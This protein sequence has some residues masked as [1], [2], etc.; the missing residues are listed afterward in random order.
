[1]ANGDDGDV[2][3]YYDENTRAFLAR[4][5]G[6]SEG[7]LHRG[8]WGEGV[9][10]R[11]GAFHFVHE[12]L[13]REIETL[14]APCPRILDLGC[15]VGASLLYLLERQAVEGFGITV[16]GEQ[17]ERVR[18]HGGA[19]WLKGD[20]CKDP[21]PAELDL[22]YG[23]ESFLHASDAVAFFRNVSQA[24]RR[25][26]RLVLVDDFLTTGAPDEALV[27]DFAWGWHAGSLL[28]LDEIDEIA[29]ASELFVVSDRDLTPYLSLDRPRDRVL[30][31]LLPLLLPLLPD[32]PRLRSLVGG[33]ALRTCLERG[34]VSYRFRVWEKRRSD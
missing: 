11:A 2:A 33:N 15:G 6:G 28:P 30:A 13:L 27:R 8:V 18:S 3:R 5:Q 17:L 12:L 25:G 20:F 16:S 22:A 14:G 34:L 23:I 29:G 21:L 32:G 4:G 7:V 31:L 24:I 10:D 26:G 19:R 9:R 1:M